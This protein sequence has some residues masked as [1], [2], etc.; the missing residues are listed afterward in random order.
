LFSTR[1][2]SPTSYC[3]GADSCMSNGYGNQETRQLQSSSKTL[4]GMKMPLHT[5]LFIDSHTFTSKGG[6]V[7]STHV[8][9]PGQIFRTGDV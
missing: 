4:V 7:E 6:K 1:F 3:S 9:F 8:Q 5:Q 2:C